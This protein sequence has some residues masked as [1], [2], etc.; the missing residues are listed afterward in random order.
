MK[1][2]KWLQLNSFFRWIWAES[3]RLFHTFNQFQTKWRIFIEIIRQMASNEHQNSTEILQFNIKNSKLK[4]ISLNLSRKS[5]I[6]PHL[7]PISNKMADIHRNNQTNGLQWHQNSTEI[8]RSS[9]KEI[10]LQFFLLNLSNLQPILNKMT[11]IYRNNQTNG[12]Q[13][14]QSSTITRRFNIENSKETAFFMAFFVVFR[15]TWAHHQSKC[16]DEWKKA[17]KISRSPANIANNRRFFAAF[18]QHF[19]AHRSKKWRKQRMNINEDCQQQWRGDI[20]KMAINNKRNLK[21]MEAPISFI[22]FKQAMICY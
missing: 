17:G 21:R 9:I 18:E 13:W 10:K 5:S 11:K 12:L 16:H 3:P 19:L 7:Q 2:K 1:N 15:P 14:H 20:K 6:I 4:L 22:F 8:L